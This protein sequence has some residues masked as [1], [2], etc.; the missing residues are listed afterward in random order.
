MRRTFDWIKTFRGTRTRFSIR[1]FSSLRGTA[2]M[3]PPHSALTQG[4]G[5]RLFDTPSHSGAIPKRR[6]V[7][8]YPE[9]PAAGPLFLLPDSR[10]YPSGLHRSRHGITEREGA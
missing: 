9:C 5:V 7:R 6:A 1:A 3:A 4:N 2:P 10:T 8:H